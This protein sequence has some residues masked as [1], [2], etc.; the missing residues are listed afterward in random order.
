MDQQFNKITEKGPTIYQKF[1][2]NGA[3]CAKNG[4]NM[5]TKMTKY[6]PKFTKN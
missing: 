5:D 3:K 2:G 1:T 6:G 4:P